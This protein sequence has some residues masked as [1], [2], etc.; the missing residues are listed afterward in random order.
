[1]AAMVSRPMNTCGMEATLLD[2]PLQNTLRHQFPQLGVH[3]EKP[4]DVS[5]IFL[6]L[7][8][9]PAGITGG[10]NLPAQYVP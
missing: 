8:G 9:A 10:P 7:A 4:G 1:M 6:P 3:L 5:Q 2:Q